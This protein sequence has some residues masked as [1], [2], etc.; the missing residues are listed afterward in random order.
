MSRYNAFS[1]YLLWTAGAIL[2][3]FV[4]LVIASWVW[5]ATFNLQEHRGRI[6]TLAS[7][8]LA[9]DVHIDGP[10]SLKF[11]LFPRISIGDV[12]IANAAWAAQ[13]D[14]LSVEHIEVEISLLSLLRDKLVIQD[15]DLAGATIRLQRGPDQSANWVFES[16]A[17]QES[18]TVAM[19]DILGLH[20]SRV[21]IIYY[22]PDRPPVAIKIDE[23]QATL[24]PDEPLSLRMNAS[25][26]NFPL[27]IELQGGTLAALLNRES[28][29]PF[30][31]TL[32]TDIRKFDFEGYIS[33]PIAFRE[34]E[35]QIASEKQSARVSLLFGHRYEPVF[36]RY[37]VKMHM[38]G[39][40]GIYS[41]RLSGVG[42][43]FDLSRIYEPGQRSQKPSLKFQ[44]LKINA[45]GSGSTAGDMLRSAS[46]DV[47]GSG[48]EIRYPI[49]T[50][51]QQFYPA[52]F[53]TL[54]AS[55]TPG[56]GIEFSLKG[57]ANHVPVQVGVSVKGLL[58]RLWK[59]QDVPLDAQLQSGA[60][61][62]R[63]TGNLSNAL[64]NATL[65]GNISIRT[66]SLA[67]IG[68]LIGQHWPESAALQAA[69]Q[70]RLDN[71]SL[72]LSNFAGQL[73]MQKVGGEVALGYES[74]FDLEVKAHA[75]RFDLHDALQDGKIPANLAFGLNGLSLAIN[76][77]G[78]SLEQ[79]VL[80]GDWEIS[81]RQGRIGWRPK[82]TDDEY[83][84]AL[85]DIRLTAKDSEPMTLAARL[86]LH[87][88][89]LKLAAQAGPLE[90]LLDMTQPQ[91]LDLQLSG[92][93][94]SATFLGA[95]QNPTADF[96]L[97]GDLKVNGQLS[98]IAR[99]INVK[100]S[101]QQPA[102]LQGH[103]AVTGKDFKLTDFVATTSGI[104]V[105]GELDYQTSRSPHLSI[106][107]SGSSIDLAPYL[108][109]DA[110]P[111]QQASHR[112]QIVPDIALDFSRYRTLDA[113]VTV[114]DLG[115]KYKGTAIA[116]I[117]ARF[118][119]DKGLFRLDPLEVRSATDGATT[120]SRLELD[121]SS[122]V[123]RLKY[124]LQA[125]NIDY[126]DLLK[127]FEISKDVSGTLDLHMNLTGEGNSLRGL[128]SSANGKIQLVANKG[129]VPKWLL[130]IWGSGLLRIFLPTNW[131]GEPYTKLNCA[132][133]SFDIADGIMRSRTL[134]ADT[135]NVTVAGQ[136]NIDWRDEKIHGLFKPQ[137]KDA[138]LFHLGTPIELSGT[139]AYP[140]VASA[141]SSIV[142][143]GKWAIGLSNPATMIVLF[144]DVG[145]KEKNPC[146][147]LL[148]QT[149]AAK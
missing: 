52:R 18:A 25:F 58:Y 10:L 85:H 74:G 80:E 109:K 36:D 60:A 119:A 4:L 141:Q 3:A 61:Y 108:K 13:P 146:E 68:D 147:A 101:R 99:M 24:Q 117:D 11:S 12:R 114:N 62:A 79:C 100:L 55:S 122:H 5:I 50:P 116:M 29:W 110:G 31:G 103:L 84:F 115:I 148:K 53:D 39:D 126:G 111:A 15:L 121:N 104:V 6:E 143:I 89:D 22:P 44:S 38:T 56:N 69:S 102:D 42:F 1:K 30:K 23:M 2:A 49:G 27:K 71:R 88:V 7:Q 70:V 106:N 41:F 98:N 130:E 37:H 43:G 125:D 59:M 132:V 138:T 120:K 87:E 97:A 94:L 134:L 46:T 123:N 142:T 57:T 28:R 129:L 137:P 67:H 51:A 82:P 16:G 47:E 118:A 112:G 78:P 63:F 83:V 72:S 127:R 105:N 66:D 140:K 149:A 136:I 54:R 77:N 32:D 26:R 45:V 9:R 40:A 86:L 91:P 139:L 107:S 76:G 64:D 133:G 34:A 131:M 95:M 33:D 8:A 65:A 124:D 93:E 81:A 75:D 20:A 48:I 96:A 135:S 73:G 92:Q 113:T 145:A 128:V 90:S 21:S 144:G 14:F 19:P 17:G 35:L